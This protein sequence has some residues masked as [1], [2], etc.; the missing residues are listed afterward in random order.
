MV[1]LEESSINTKLDLGG[2]F[3]YGV[4]APRHFLASGVPAV[5]KNPL[6]TVSNLYE[7]V[8]VAGD[9]KNDNMTYCTIHN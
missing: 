7:F 2:G 3:C 5:S 9:G 6:A 8:S 4:K 1:L